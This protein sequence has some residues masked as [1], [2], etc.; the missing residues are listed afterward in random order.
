[1]ILM[2]GFFYISIEQN[3]MKMMHY[4]LQNVCLPV[5]FLLPYSVLFTVES[6]SLLHLLFIS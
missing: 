6:L 1:M 2:V 5:G 4:L 3:Q